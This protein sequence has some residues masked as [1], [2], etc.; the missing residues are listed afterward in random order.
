MIRSKE[1]SNRAAAIIITVMLISCFLIAACN[2][3]DIP[4]QERIKQD[5]TD[6]LVK[7]TRVDASNIEG[8]R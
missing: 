8:R 2:D 4:N 1:P 7:D 6:Q 3:S 5:V